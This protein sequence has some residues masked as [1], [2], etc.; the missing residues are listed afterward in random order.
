MISGGLR[1]ALYVVCQLSPSSVQEVLGEKCERISVP[2]MP[3]HMKVSY[4][5]LLNSLHEIFV[6][7]K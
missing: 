3:F 2:S 1:Y 4:G 7:M 5:T 6:V